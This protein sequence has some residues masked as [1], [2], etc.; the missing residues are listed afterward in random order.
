MIIDDVG[1]V[2]SGESVGFHQDHVIDFFGIHEDVA[3]DVVVECGR[4]GAS[5]NP[6]AYHMRGV[7]SA[8]TQISTSPVIARARSQAELL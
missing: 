5:R 6:K 2:I 3:E 1:K 4:F 8:V 7:S